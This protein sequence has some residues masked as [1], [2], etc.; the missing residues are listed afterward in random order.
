VLKKTTKPE[1]KRS[2]LKERPLRYPGQSLDDEIQ[3]I[4]W[5]IAAWV[6]AALV[7]I[8]LALYEWW[9][10]YIGLPPQPVGAAVVAAA[11]TIYGLL[12]IRQLSRQL[13]YLRLGRDGERIV[14]QVL[15]EL[16]QHGCAV[17]HDVVGTGFNVD[18]VVV[19]PHGIYAVETKTCSKP[20]NTN[21][22]IVFDGE[23]VVVSG[24]LPDARPIRQAMAN[25]DWLR[26]DVLLASTGK[27]FPVTPVL[28]FPGWWVESKCRNE[29][30]WV[31]N[32]GMLSAEISR[33]P[34]VLTEADAHMAAYHLSRFVRLSS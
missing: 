15:E 20:A 14:G 30:I 34:R 28:L 24:C 31:L 9:H 2:P 29:R 6:G 18:H 4:R 25:A 3:R 5:K 17:F 1:K 10:W 22:T 7:L 26:R 32:P 11:V 27:S 13:P 19:S 33:Q 16:R 21:A 23:K 8:V 12:K